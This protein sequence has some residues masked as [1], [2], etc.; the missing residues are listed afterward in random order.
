VSARRSP[1]EAVLT[2]IVST[3]RAS[4]GV[5]AIATGGVYNNVPQGTAFPY[6]EVSCPSDR[7]VDTCGRFGAELLVDVKAV[8]QA[9]GDQEPSRMARPGDPG[10]ELSAADAERARDARD[11]VGERRPVSGSRERDHH[12]S[13]RRD[14]SRLG[15]TEFYIE[16][17]GHAEATV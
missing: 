14:V 8:S 9:F 11:D 12:A 6:L 4:A 5:S 13:P 10:L 17:A 1:V 3:L 15:A 16:G 7:P 2:A